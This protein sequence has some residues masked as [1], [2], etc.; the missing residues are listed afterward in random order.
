MIKL[1]HTDSL[2]IK[3]RIGD[4]MVS[5]VLV[6]G[7][8]NSDILFWEVFQRIN[9]DK[10]MIWPVKTS[11]HAFNGA[12]VKPLIVAALPVYVVD[13]IIE[14]KF[15]VKTSFHAFNGAKCKTLSKSTSLTNSSK[16]LKLSTQSSKL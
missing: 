1:S 14:V 3:L 11:F 15:L 4:V 5:R 13:R 9:V 2:V 12:E 8:S 6:D 16:S 10:E 7:G